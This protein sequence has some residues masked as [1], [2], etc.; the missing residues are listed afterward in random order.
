M[1]QEH[2]S[3]R[4][5]EQ[6]RR[7]SYYLFILGYLTT[8]IA[9]SWYEGSLWTPSTIFFLLSATLFSTLYLGQHYALDLF[10]GAVYSLVP[11]LVS[12]RLLSLT[13][14]EPAGATRLKG[15]LPFPTVK[16]RGGRGLK[17]NPGHGGVRGR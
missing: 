1:K 6:P 15:T 3:P 16:S 10:G 4:F 12:E 2:Y 17:E 5:V 11:C 9:F 14:E 13:K 8:L 7:Y